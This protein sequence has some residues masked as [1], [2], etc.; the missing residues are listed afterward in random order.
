MTTGS[1]TDSPWLLKKLSGHLSLQAFE[2][3]G[4]LPP[5]DYP[6]GRLLED[7][8]FPETSSNKDTRWPTPGSRP[9]EDRLPE[10]GHE[11]SRLPEAG[12]DCTHQDCTHIAVVR[13]GVATVQPTTPD[14]RS[15]RGH[16]APYGPAPVRRGTVAMLASMSPT[17]GARTA[18][19][20]R[21]PLP[22]RH[23][24]TARPPLVGQ[25]CGRLPTAG[26]LPPSKHAPY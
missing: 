25:G 15:R 4:R 21:A 10:A 18:R 20:E 5:T 23:L 16:R 6:R 7:D 12:Q 24:K 11:E 9:Q 22:E 13:W 2:A 3:Q 8:P 14:S 17:T 1:L 19:G 26:Y